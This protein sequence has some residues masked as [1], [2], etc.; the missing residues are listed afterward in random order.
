MASIQ[1]TLEAQLQALGSRKVTV[2][3]YP[4]SYRWGQKYIAYT[5]LSGRTDY[6]IFLGSA[7]AVRTGQSPAF[8]TPN[9]ALKE[10]LLARAKRETKPTPAK[11]LTLAILL[12]GLPS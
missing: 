2:K 11:T 5:S 7:G 4:Q 10:K 6:F 3:D 1:Q 12:K 9:E 8:C